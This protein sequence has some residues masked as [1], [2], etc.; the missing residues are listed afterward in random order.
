MEFKVRPE[1]TVP[2]RKSR[3]HRTFYL[4]K[5]RYTANVLE[6]GVPAVGCVIHVCSCFSDTIH[7]S[8]AWRYREVP[9]RGPTDSGSC[10]KAGN[11]ARG[12]WRV[13]PFFESNDIRPDE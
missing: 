4:L 10:Y 8:F 3:N 1:R 12:P 11:V 5:L 9:D 2:F 7:E 6:N 13:R